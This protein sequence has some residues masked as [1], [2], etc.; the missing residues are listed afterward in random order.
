MNGWMITYKVSITSR[1][2]LITSNVL[3]LSNVA[4]APKSC[5]GVGVGVEPL[6]A[7]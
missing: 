1:Q 7:E 6:E 4:V 3:K 5:P 2:S